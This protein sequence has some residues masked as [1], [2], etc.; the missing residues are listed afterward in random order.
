MTAVKPR[1]TVDDRIRAA[2]W[3]ATQ[4][5]RIFTVWSTTDAGVCRCP[6]GVACDNA[7]K[8]P[9]TPHGFKDATTDPDRIKTLL[10][11]G[12]DPNYGMLCPEGVFALDVDGEGVAQLAELERIHG[13]LPPTLRTTTAHGEH[14]FLRWPEDLPRP[15]GTMF[16]YVTRWGSGPRAGYVIGPRSVHASGAVYSP[17]GVFDIAELPEAWARKVVESAAPASSPNLITIQGGYVMPERIPAGGARYPEILAYTAALY[18][19]ALSKD[20][21][22]VLVRDVLAPRFAEP[23]GEADLRSRFERATDKL[24]ERLGAPRLVPDDAPRDISDLFVNVVDYCANVPDEVP[25][26]SYPLAYFGGVTLLAG[27]WKGGKSTLTAQLQ[28]A[29]ETGEEFLDFKIDIGPT[30]LVTEEGGIPV[31]RKVGGLH[32]LVILDRQR[33]V[34]R[35]LKFDHVLAALEEFCT[36][37]PATP[38]VVFLDTFAVWGDI[39]DENDAPEVTGAISKLTV[40]AQKTNTAIVLVHHVR[41]DGGSHGRGIRGSGAIAATVDIFAVL[42]Y[43]EA[44][45]GQS[46]DRILKVEGR[47]LEALNRRLSFDPIARTYRLVDEE[48][49][50]LAR[51]EGWLKEVPAS[52]LGLTTGA[53]QETWGIT[54]QGVK[55]RVEYLRSKGRMRSETGKVGNAN[56]RLHWSIPAAYVEASDDVD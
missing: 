1:P 15:L 13:P 43:P 54:R 28:R 23:L 37:S 3:F 45:D 35:G 42:E 32:D 51:I 9:V 7:G 38:A 53:L 55:P 24:A 2:L 12:S 30:V 20:E 44:G 34:F 21:M 31:K 8:H 50:E 46:T 22:W 48:A 11:A 18:N 56:A 52:G 4:G 40:L 41:K 25:W 5:F 39:E 10:S 16:G 14:V 49:A 17:G 6:K 36:R 29:R 33:A 26:A 27:I 47:V 19:R